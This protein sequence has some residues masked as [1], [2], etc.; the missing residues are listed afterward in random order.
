MNIGWQYVVIAVLLASVVQFARLDAVK[1]YKLEQAANEAKAEARLLKIN[2]DIAA[3]ESDLA[4]L[5]ERELQELQ[6]E[7]DTFD[8]GDLSPVF[9][10]TINRL[11]AT[12]SDSNR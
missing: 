5:R 10:H 8:D 1:G 12:H 4:A 9:I 3:K 11:Y 6:N 2:R 7:I